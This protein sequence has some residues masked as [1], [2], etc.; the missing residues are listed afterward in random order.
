VVP[1]DRAAPRV[2]RREPAAGP[3]AS[4]G[5]TTLG[6]GERIILRAVA[7]YPEGANREQ[8]TVLT[9][10]KRSS[11]DTYL[12]RLQAAGLVE[13]NGNGLHATYAG[14]VALGEDYEPLPTGSALL[15]YWLDRLGGGERTILETLTKGDA[16]AWI[17]R[18]AISDQTSYKRSSRDTYIQRLQARRLVVADRGQV[19]AADALFD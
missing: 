9:G 16:P 3:A 19:R 8:L 13:Q 11:R 4:G 18:D 14:M 6:K 15:A 1:Q 17:D 5:G 12:Q 7:Q 10:Y 2:R